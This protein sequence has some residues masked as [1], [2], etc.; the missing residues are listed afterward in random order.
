MQNP[1]GGHTARP[2]LPSASSPA[3]P[4]IGASRPGRSFLHGLGAGLVLNTL[5][6]LVALDK[7][8]DGN[9]RRIAIAI[10]GL[11]HPRIAAG[12][13]LVA[14]PQGLEELLDHR[15]IAHAR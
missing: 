8:D 3:L 11:E 6:A 14:G 4:Q 10:T 12:A 5:H 1:G 13:A 9:G 2:P 7:F 15:F